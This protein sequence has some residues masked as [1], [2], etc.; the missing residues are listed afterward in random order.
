VSIYLH[1]YCR[2]VVYSLASAAHR[3]ML[4]QRRYLHRNVSLSNIIFSPSGGDKNL[5]RLVDFDLAKRV[6]FGLGTSTQ[7]DSQTVC[8]RRSKSPVGR[9]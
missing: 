6:E 7:D 4:L 3:D 8:P 2:R 9:S 5:G 1:D